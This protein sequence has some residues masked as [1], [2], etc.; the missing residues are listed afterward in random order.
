MSKIRFVTFDAFN[1]LWK[2]KEPPGKVYGRIANSKYGCNVD[3]E[4]SAQAFVPSYKTVSSQ[5]PNFGYRSISG[6][7]FW[8]KIITSTLN[9]GGLDKP[10]SKALINEL[11]DHFATS[12][13][14]KLYQ[15]VV[16]CLVELKSSGRV[17]IG[18]ISNSDSRTEEV[19]RSFR[20][21]QYFDVV[22]LSGVFGIAKPRTEI[23]REALKLTDVE[24]QEAIHIGDDVLDFEGAKAAGMNGLIINRAI[25]SSEVTGG[26]E[27]T[28]TNTTISSLRA[29]L[30]LVEQGNG[31]KI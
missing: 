7:E 27:N 6:Y 3:L 18:L 21:R 19:L 24:A 9:A 31:I 2:L 16:P 15:D 23:F 30:K 4:R 13:P 12:A 8:E 26:T 17:K 1:T 25:Q 5:Y 28:D 10:P 20:I 11:Y 29:V 14:Y 22:V